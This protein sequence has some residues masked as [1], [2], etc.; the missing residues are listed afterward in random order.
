MRPA[1][2]PLYIAAVLRHVGRMRPVLPPLGRIG[3]VLPPLYKTAVLRPGWDL[4]SS[5]NKALLLYF[6]ARV[7][8]NY[9][10]CDSV[11]SGEEG[12]GEEGLG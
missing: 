7:S 6:S 11:P 5:L 3:P 10:T 9:G 4:G 12:L 1:L 8:V 2:P